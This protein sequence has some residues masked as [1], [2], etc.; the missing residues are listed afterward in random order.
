MHDA[1]AQQ[2]RIDADLAHQVHWL[3]A[4]TRGQG[5]RSAGFASG[6]ELIHGTLKPE[7]VVVMRC[8][9]GSQ[10]LDSD[11]NRV[12]AAAPCPICGADAECRIHAEEAFACCAQQPSDWRL[13]NGGWLHR[14]DAFETKLSVGYMGHA[15]AQ[16]VADGSVG[17]L[18]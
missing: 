12:S 1:A 13:S 10:S 3:P 9:A 15:P 7:G 5:T 17:V 14:T 18:P 2:I 16:P 11:W 6:I 4:I 8:I